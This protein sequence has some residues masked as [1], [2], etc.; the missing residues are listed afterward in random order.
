MSCTGSCPNNGFINQDLW[1]AQ[2]NNSACN[3]GKCWIEAGYINSSGVSSYFWTGNRPNGGYSF[4][5]NT[6]VLPQ[7]I[8]YGVLHEE[9]YRTSYETFAISRSIY[10]CNSCTTF[11]TEAS[12]FNIMDSNTIQIGSELAG[13]A[14]A[15]APK[16]HYKTNYWRDSNGNWQ[17][18]KYGGYNLNSPPYGYW[19][20]V[21]SPSSTGDWVTYCC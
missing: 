5:W 16:N 19:N 20:I 9:I 21:P 15:S 1:L 8:Q 4:H 3:W 13:S 17:P 11:G 10:Y 12:T 18:E 2:L 14:G 7:D 6:V